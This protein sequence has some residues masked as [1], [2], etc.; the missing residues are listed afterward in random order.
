MGYGVCIGGGCMSRNQIRFVLAT[1]VTLL[2]VTVAYQLTVTMRSQRE[3]DRRMRELVGDLSSNAE[4][5]MQDFRRFKMRDGKKVWEIAARQARYSQDS[6][7]AIVDAPEFSLYLSD[8]QVIALRC[9]EG[10]VHLDPG[11][12]EVLRVELKGNIE[13]RLGDFS[14]KTQEAVF[15]SQQDTI[16]AS[17]MVQIMGPGLLVEGQGYLVD[18]RESRL[19]LNSAVQTTVSRSE[20]G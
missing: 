12:L 19:T 5:R 4:H 10:R 17:G 15:E 13:M 20:E 9:E 18:I 11:K 16:S 1:A 2:L 7:E 6:S 8:D 14:V 3:R